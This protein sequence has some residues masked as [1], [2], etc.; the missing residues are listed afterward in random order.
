M[1]I[2]SMKGGN[3]IFNTMAAI[4]MNFRAKVIKMLMTV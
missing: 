2:K 3:Q 1:Q 4:A